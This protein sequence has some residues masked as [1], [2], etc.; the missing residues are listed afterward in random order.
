SCFSTRLA[1]SSASRLTRSSAGVDPTFCGG[2]PAH[3]A[4]T[5][6]PSAA[7]ADNLHAKLMCSEPNR[8]EGL[9]SRIPQFAGAGENCAG[10]GGALGNAGNAGHDAI[11]LA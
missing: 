8:Y 9:G 7:P 11:A 10:L 5:A 1:R 3:A 2:A 4:T 6:N